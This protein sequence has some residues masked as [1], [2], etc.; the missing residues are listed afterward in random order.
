MMN[1]FFLSLVVAGYCSA[2]AVAAPILQS[3]CAV[4][5]QM[6]ANSSPPQ[7]GMATWLAWQDEGDDAVTPS[8]SEQL[9]AASAV[10]PIPSCARITNLANGRSVVVLI[11]Q[12][13]PARSY[14]L[15]QLGNAAADALRVRAATPI[16][17]QGLAPAAPD[18]T[19]PTLAHADK[20]I[21]LWSPRYSTT[22]QAELQLRQ[23]KHDGLH[24]LRIAPGLSD[25]HWSYRLRLGPLPVGL[26]AT[27][28]AKTLS[29]SGWKF[30]TSEND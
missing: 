27:I 4:A 3:A 5:Q 16:E 2:P 12:R 22:M 10:L 1:K 9:R 18:A 30:Q 19:V 25:G 28:L 24:T 13:S 20:K 11:D 14:G 26:S 23:A 21:Y 15:V 8:S 17:L 29:R 6:S 7:R